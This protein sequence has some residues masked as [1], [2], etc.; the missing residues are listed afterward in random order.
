MAIATNTIDALELHFQEDIENVSNIE[1]I[2]NILEVVCRVTGMGFAAIARVTEDRWITCLSNDNLK[3]GLRPGDELKVESTICYEIEKSHQSVLISNVAENVNFCNHHTP[4]QYGFQ[5]YISVPIVLKNNQFFGT[6]CALDPSPADL[7]RPEVLMMFELYANMIAVHLNSINEVRTTQNS[8]NQELE[9]S[10]LR[11]QF[12][13][14]LGHD[15]RNPVGAIK[16]S[17][18]LLKKAILGTREQRLVGIIQNS[19]YRMAGLI[20]NV[21]DFARG[22]LGDGIILD[23]QNEQSIEQ[24]LLGV[25]D[26]L[27]AVAPEKKI[28]P[29]FDLKVIVKGDYRRI[30]QLFSNIL[31]N[32]ISYGEQDAPISVYAIVDGDHFK[33]SVHNSGEVIPEEK[34]KNLFKPFQRGSSH[35]N[36]DGLGLGLYISAE[37]AKAHGGTLTVCS[38]AEETCFELTIPA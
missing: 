12:I 14:V 16:N 27:Q 4:L 34:L 15:L 3:F 8:L 30:A 19:T 13:A 36:K 28:L 23:Y 5:S 10:V 31:A 22:R 11:D 32:A 2:T 18:E 1:G 20:D 37:I 25:I 6:L 24:L 33:L 26:E 17:A 9:T 38:I 7:D 21:L 35:V 29:Q